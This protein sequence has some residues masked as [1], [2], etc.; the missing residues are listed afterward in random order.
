[1]EQTALVAT[2]DPIASLA[3]ARVGTGVSLSGKPPVGLAY[4]CSKETPA[5]S[6]CEL[7]VAQPIDAAGRQW[8]TA[9][10]TQIGQGTGCDP[11]SADRPTLAL[12][13]AGKAY[14]AYRYPQ[15]DGSGNFDVAVA[16]GTMASGF[17]AAT[18]FEDWHAATG[19]PKLTLDASYKP[20]LSFLGAG[21]IRYA[22][23]DGDGRWR[24]ETIVPLEQAAYL[25]P[26]DLVISGGSSRAPTPVE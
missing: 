6:V 9:L 16:S 20:S 5:G 2:S 23:Q 10:V 7:R 3:V 24:F 17:Q 26:A 15:A 14:V 8:Q 19:F 11:F 21:G 13:Y 22:W 4:L 18:Q 12:D 25:E 1:M